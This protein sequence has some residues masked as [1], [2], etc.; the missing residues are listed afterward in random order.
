L[1]RGVKARNKIKY[2]HGFEVKTRRGFS[3][4]ANNNFY[5]DIVE[6]KRRELGPFN[7]EKHTPSDDGVKRVM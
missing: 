4:H 6:T 5:N 1:F 3:T 7:Y 2:L